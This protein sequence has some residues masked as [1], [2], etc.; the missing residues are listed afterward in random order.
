MAGD[1]GAALA[2]LLGQVAPAE[3]FAF[4]S[5]AYPSSGPPTPS[6]N[7]LVLGDV[8]VR[9]VGIT[10]E[11]PLVFETFECTYDSWQVVKAGP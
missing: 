3:W 5:L 1:G 2:G 11:G 7:Q 4:S 8:L 9:Q 10:M 6:A